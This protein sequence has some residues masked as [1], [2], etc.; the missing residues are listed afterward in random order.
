MSTLTETIEDLRAAK[1]L[2]ADEKRW[3]KG[4]YEDPDTGRMCALGA[5]RRAAGDG[6][7]TER[8]DACRVALAQALPAYWRDKGV[9][10]FNDAP[11]R[12]HPQVLALFDRAI[13]DLE[14]QV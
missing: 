9:A 6:L 5:T 12:K 7:W 10:A 4:W 13:K 11:G 3:F 1:A 2:I 8:S 14:A